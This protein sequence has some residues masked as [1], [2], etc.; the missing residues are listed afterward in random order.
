MKDALGEI[1]RNQD[2]NRL[3]ADLAMAT[4]LTDP[5]RQKLSAM[6]DMPSKLA[7]GF[8]SSMRNIQ[9]LTGETNES[10]TALS[11][12]LLFIGSSAVAGP[13]A[14]ADAYYN[15][16]SGIGDASVRLDAL[17]SA[18]ALAEAGQE[19]LGAATNG[20]I[21]VI[22]AYG[23]SAE[24]V[25]GLSDVFF[26]TLNKGKGTLGGFVTSMNSIAGLSANLGI[27]FDE[28]GS[29]MAIISKTQTEAV[30]ATQL[31][32]AMVALL[33]PNSEMTK[34]L[35]LL[36]F[37]SGSALVKQYGLAESLT[38]VKSALGGSDD[39]MAKALGSSEALQA[40]I[41]LTSDKYGA[42]AKEY[43]QGLSGAASTA[44]VAQTQSYEA[45]VAK[46]QA[47]QDSLRIQ[48]GGDINAIKG[49]FVDIG[50]GFLTHVAAPIMSSPVGEVF[51]GIAAATGLAAKT[52]LDLG[53]G[54]LNTATQLVLLTATVQNAGGFAKLF[55]SS[56]DGMRSRIGLLLTPLKAAG[57][58]LAAFSASV[59]SVGFAQTISSG[60]SGMASVITGLGK[61]IIG[62]L[63]K[64]GAWIASTWAAAAANVAAFWPVYAIIGGVALLAA[65]A[66]LLV[67]H[68]DAVSA[69]F[70]GLWHKITGAFTAAFDWIR[71]LLGGVSNKVLGVIAVF[72]PFIGIPA[73]VIK[74]WET[75]QAFFAGLWVRIT[76]LFTAVWTGITQTVAAVANW[77]SG[78]WD[79][80]AGGFAGA[81]LWIKDLFTSV[82]ES[83]K[84]VVMSFVEWLSPVIDAIIAPFKGIGNAIGSIVGTVGG[85]FGKT[86]ELG[87]TELAKAGENKT[88]T[89]PPSLLEQL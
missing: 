68:W 84:G 38:M 65:G 5:F 16:T 44:L 3:A 82:W 60:L 39:G 18:V 51:Q 28:L 89:S 45:R 58:G 46:L 70:A 35:D 47:V 25:G 81:W 23:T 86:V 24:N 21:S 61:A 4:S 13:N 37:S 79:T 75:I 52:A 1:N 63:P 42:F 57:A 71:N 62:A 78:V 17:R 48:I 15:V 33:K 41:E 64:M 67:K 88:K 80:V 83:I 87:K 59:K 73:L 26:Q 50:A 77:F 10:L 72:F 55:K 34:A 6:M 74:N 9:S 40:S 76:A 43:A 22:N 85:W 7:G 20:L 19:D 54:V 32:S 27:G 49:F 31:K 12:E 2:M 66:V 30:A 11:K 56:L 8:D 14:V 69:F 53:S 29:S 36:G